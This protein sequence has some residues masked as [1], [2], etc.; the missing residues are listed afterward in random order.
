MTPV[1]NS[2]DSPKPV[3]IPSPATGHDIAILDV[4]E[5]YLSYDAETCPYHQSSW[6]RRPRV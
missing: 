1:G 5:P 6:N 4:E 2:A 3:F